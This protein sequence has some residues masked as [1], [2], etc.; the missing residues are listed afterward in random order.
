MTSQNPDSDASECSMTHASFRTG[1]IA[2]IFMTP[3][4]ASGDHQRDQPLAAESRRPARVV[5][6]LTPGPY[7]APPQRYARRRRREAIQREQPVAAVRVEQQA[8]GGAEP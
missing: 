6:S 4:S 2:M 8:I 1:I 3:P 5:Q 7:H